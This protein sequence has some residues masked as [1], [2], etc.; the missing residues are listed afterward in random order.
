M[1]RLRKRLGHKISVPLWLVI[2]LAVS[3]V[4][5]AL[6]L[7][8]ILTAQVQ[9]TGEPLVELAD[10]DS[11]TSIVERDTV[12]YWNVTSTNKE[13]T[14]ITIVLRLEFDSSDVT[15][16]TFEGT[17]VTCTWVTNWTCDSPSL[18][19]VGGQLILWHWTFVFTINKFYNMQMY[20]VVP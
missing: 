18:P 13:G 11:P 9:V 17:P 16:V 20:A 3:S 10:F 1:E 4:V 7:S 6:V 15:N 5:S 14:P 12:V 19:H 2:V 8:N